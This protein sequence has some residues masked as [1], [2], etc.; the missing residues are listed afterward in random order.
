[1][2]IPGSNLF[3]WAKVCQKLTNAKALQQ[4]Y[5]K[6]EVKNKVKSLNQLIVQWLH[7]HP[8]ETLNYFITI[9]FI[10]ANI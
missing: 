6:I 2:V 10:P 3:F 1:V 4:P 9:V 8:L 7:Y 5:Y